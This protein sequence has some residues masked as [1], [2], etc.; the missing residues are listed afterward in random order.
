MIKAILGFTWLQL[1]WD[2]LRRDNCSM[3]EL[4]GLARMQRSL[5]NIQGRQHNIIGVVPGGEY[6]Y[7]SQG[8]TWDRW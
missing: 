4:K 2:N 5:S 3:G 8:V 6:W 1:C 7:R